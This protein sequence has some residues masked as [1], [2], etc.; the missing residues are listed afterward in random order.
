MP[1]TQV[2]LR[3]L[4]LGGFLRAIGAEEIYR[5]TAMVPEGPASGAFLRAELQKL[6][7]RVDRSNPFFRGRFRAF[8]GQTE[9]ATDADF[10]QRYAQLPV[11]TKDDYLDAGVAVMDAAYQN[12]LEE[13]TLRFGT[14]AW[15][16]FR[17]LRSTDFVLPMC[18]G[19]TTAEPLVVRMNKEHTYA[20]LFSFFACWRRMGWELGQ[21]V[22]VFYPAGTYNIDE[23]AAFNRLGAVTG[24][25]II[26]FSHLDEPTIEYLLSEMD[27]FRPDLLLIFPSPMN[28]IAQTIRRRGLRLGHQPR[29]IN[30]SGETFFD[31]QRSNIQSVFP[32]SRI[33]D[34]YGSV[35][36]GEIAH[37][38]GNAL[39]VF[40]HLAYVETVGQSAD[41]GE[42]VITRLGLSAFPFIRYA[43]K[44]LFRAGPRPEAHLGLSQIAWIEGKNTTFLEFAGGR[45]IHAS[46][47]NRLVN[48]VNAGVGDAIAEIK[49]YERGAQ[50]LEIQLILRNPGAEEAIRDALQRQLH[51]QLGPNVDC[52]IRFV[53]A[54]DHDYR[55]KYRP[56]ERNIDTEWAGGVMGRVGVV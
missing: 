11:F 50:S 49:V 5:R 47:F 36:L 13:L 15:G 20:L 53:D 56:I 4:F 19:G 17:Q 6:L 43:M 52:A 35:E 34:S 37:Q 42:A 48:A 9:K 41:I 46:F 23:L 25:R 28:V 55:R 2:R 8:L 45:R 22:L 29:M 54:I 31:C 7:E 1:F 16:L 3:Q 18:T 10:F 51:E 12:R 14:T 24:F 39:E 40:G 32:R 21:R 38:A 30:V 27:A 26:L 33:E 44:D